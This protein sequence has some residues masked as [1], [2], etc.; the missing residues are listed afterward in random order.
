MPSD[1]RFWIKIRIAF[2]AGVLIFGLLMYIL[3][4]KSVISLRIT[5]P[6]A[7]LFTMIAVIILNIA[8]KKYR[9]NL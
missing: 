8:E 4:L 3:H 2:V 6:L 7:M 9:N 1:R 5:L